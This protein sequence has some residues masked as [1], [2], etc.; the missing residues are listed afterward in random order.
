MI[1]GEAVPEMKTVPCKENK[2]QC[3]CRGGLAKVV[4]CQ[5]RP[6]VIKKKKKRRKKKKKTIENTA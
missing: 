4:Q 1:N 5:K 6:I 2:C 3:Q